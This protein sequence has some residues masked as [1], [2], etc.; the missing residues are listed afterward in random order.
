[1]KLISRFSLGLAL[2]AAA[3]WLF[4][5]ESG[6][7]LRRDLTAR[8]GDLWG[9]AS[10]TSAMFGGETGDD[11]ATVQDKIEATRQRL[12]AELRQKDPTPGA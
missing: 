6:G 11:P 7:S 9:G 4:G 5:T 10:P 2:G 3:A 8:I 12:K 1:M